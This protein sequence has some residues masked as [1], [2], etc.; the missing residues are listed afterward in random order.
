MIDHAGIPVSD[1]AP[2]KR[3]CS[4]VLQTLGATPVM[5]VPADRSEEGVAACAFGRDGKPT[6]WIGGA[7]EMPGTPHFAFVVDTREA[8]V[9]FHRTALAEGATDNGAPGLRP[10]YHPD[11]YGAFVLDRDGYN[12]DAVCH[13]PETTT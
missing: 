12:I 7:V 13:K 4:T 8:V 2:S 3:F 1:Y 10:H 5:E 11:C 9:A 6:F